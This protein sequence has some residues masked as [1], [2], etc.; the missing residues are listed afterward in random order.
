MRPGG[1]GIIGTGYR[2]RSPRTRTAAGAGIATATYRPAGLRAD[3]VRT[4]PEA[5]GHAGGRRRGRTVAGS[6]ASVPAPRWP[7]AVAGVGAWRRSG[8]H[9]RPG[10]VADRT[11]TSRAGVQR[12]DASA[13]RPRLP[14][15][16]VAALPGH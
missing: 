7:E 2:R 5:A 8:R 9:R 4:R 3:D 16:R 15:S 13:A 12:R 1:R 10:A 14:T 6:G 11:H